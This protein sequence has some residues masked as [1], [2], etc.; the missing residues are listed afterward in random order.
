MWRGAHRT[1]RRDEAG[2]PR[3]SASEVGSSSDR[4]PLG[5]PRQKFR[6]A[7]TRNVRPL[8]GSL[9]TANCLLTGAE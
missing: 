9:S 7:E 1:V 5:A 4:A 2:R 6:L 3:R 8:W